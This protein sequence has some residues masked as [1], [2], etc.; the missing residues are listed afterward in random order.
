ML[1][2]SCFSQPHLRKALLEMDMQNPA[3]LLAHAIADPED[4]KQFTLNAA[5]N[6]DGYTTVEFSTETDLKPNTEVLTSILTL[7]FNHQQFTRIDQT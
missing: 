7:Q 4:L 1:N 2:N 5:V 3:Q 6:T